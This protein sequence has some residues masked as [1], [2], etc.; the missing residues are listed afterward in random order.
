MHN[1]ETIETIPP[2]ARVAR[3]RQKE[4]SRKHTST[5]PTRPT[6]MHACNFERME[7]CAR[8]HLDLNMHTN[9]RTHILTHLGGACMHACLPIQPAAQAAWLTKPAKF[10]VKK[11]KDVHHTSNFKFPGTNKD[12]VPR[13]VPT[14]S[15]SRAILGLLRLKSKERKQ[16][17]LTASRPGAVLRQTLHAR[18]ACAGSGHSTRR[19]QRLAPACGARY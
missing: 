7:A 6:R 9:V 19:W 8:A 14:P 3:R 18:L 15:G 11:Q 5:L 12:R 4:H 10:L 16:S 1:N 17:Q 13:R 2:W